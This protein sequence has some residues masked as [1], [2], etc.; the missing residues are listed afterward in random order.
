MAIGNP[1]LLNMQAFLFNEGVRW[2]FSIQNAGNGYA[3]NIVIFIICRA[4]RGLIQ[5]T[6]SHERG[7]MYFVKEFAIMFIPNLPP[8]TLLPSIVSQAIE[9]I[10]VE[11]VTATL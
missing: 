8:Q 6:H 1:E 7:P 5:I 9:C 11:K 2:L 10:L 4:R 3:K